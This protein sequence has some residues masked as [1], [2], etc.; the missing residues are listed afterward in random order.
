MLPGYLQ[1]PPRYLFFTGKGGVGK[2]SLA[3]AT[4][5]HLADAGR[6]VLLVSTD[7]A[8]NISQVF[9]QRIGYAITPITAVPGLF[10]LEI[11]PQA[12][13]EAYRERILGPLRGQ[14]DDAEFAKVQ[15]GISGACTT[16]IASFNEFTDLL[17]SD[18][19]D[20]DHVI[21]DT[22][23][24]GHTLRLLQ[25]PGEWSGFLD[26]GKGNAS[27][28]GPLA[29]LDK[30]KR[31][32]SSAVATLA[33]ANRTLMILVA[34]P[35]SGSLLEA[36]R[37][38]GEL[39]SLGVRNQRLVING[40][41]PAGGSDDALANA[42]IARQ[43]AAIEV[44]PKA[45]DQLDRDEI[46]LR[47]INMVGVDAL[48]TLFADANSPEAE[49]IDLAPVN[50][51]ELEAMIDDLAE[52]DSGLIMLM[53]K[54]GVG[55]TTMAAAIAIALADRG[56]QV[57][58]TTTDPAAHLTQTLAEGDVP[59]LTV[60]RID[61]AQELSAYQ[62]H[63][64]ATRG[65]KMD[66]D[67]YAALEED[68]RSPCYEEVA[69][70]QAFSRIIRE[71]RRSIVVV[72]TAPTGHTL[73]LMD[74]TGAYHHEV[75]RSMGGGRFQTPLMRLQDADHT[76]IVLVTLPEPTPVQEASDLQSDLARAKITPWGWIVNN[77]LSGT[78]TSHPVLAARATAESP[79]IGHVRDELSTKMALVPMQPEEPIG[80]ESLRKLTKMPQTAESR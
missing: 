28:L 13:V 21:F 4:A 51:P 33:D 3:S 53:G 11:D 32:Y 9:G 76:K 31:S 10:A 48:R 79:L 25:L 46:A 59:N 42:T 55:K 69:V 36:A 35:Q 20:Y 80:V 57:H 67:E 22:A 58:L 52:Q 27:C 45:L 2:T 68:L 37:T 29:G 64:L 62:Q 74:T 60:S 65:A 1:S 12:A 6:R 24:T 30:Q 49:K 66:P 41:L 26:R 38:H 16:E 72:D 14:I 34:R 63:V 54:G 17:T 19:D 15:E 47:A 73:L 44:M 39:L 75:E 5:V 56:K 23:P 70:F 77:A 61:P 43:R 40:V 50:A 7:P 8:S 78:A 18:S 71:A